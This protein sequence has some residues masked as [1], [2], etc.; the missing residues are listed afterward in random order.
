MPVNL[1]D[2]DGI[3]LKCAL[4]THSTESDGDVAPDALFAKHD[5]AGF[6]VLAITDHWRLTKVPSTPS[7]LALPASELTYDIERPG[8]TSDVL[9][10]GIESIPDDPGGDRRNWLVN[11]EEHWEQ[12]TFPDLT[13]A[14]LF[15]EEQGGV[16]YVAHPYWTGMDARPLIEGS[17]FCGLE[18]FN[19]ESELECGRG[20]SSMVWDA[21][22]E[23]GKLLHAIATDDAHVTDDHIDRGWTCV[24]VAERSCEA[25]LDALRTGRFYASSGPVLRAVRRDGPNVE[26]ECSPCRALVLQMEAEKGCSVVAGSPN[27]S[28]G[29]VLAT[30]E[31]G[32]ITRAVLESPWKEPRFVRLRAVDA[33]G[34]SAWT[35]TL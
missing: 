13:A 9:V 5:A 6:D 11:E 18:V 14:G 20:D 31:D 2:A 25:V 30:D 35:N 26:V 27:S 28:Y 22:L 29:R 12:R 1:F 7:L 8:M 32:L 10:Y 24:K 16:A 23:A 34:C 33:A 3:W 15:A 19:A 4:H 21:A 17:H